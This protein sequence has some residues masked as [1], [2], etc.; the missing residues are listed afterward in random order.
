M[1]IKGIFLLP[2][3]VTAAFYQLAQADAVRV[4]QIDNSSLLINQRVGVY[5]SVTGEGGVPV[6]GLDSD[7]FTLYESSEGLR[8]ER[9]VIDIREGVKICGVVRIDPGHIVLQHR[10]D[11]VK[12]VDVWS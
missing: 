7:V 3:F 9:P 10:S 4:A 12:V 11:Q 8:L 5:V 1:R 6:T 2:L